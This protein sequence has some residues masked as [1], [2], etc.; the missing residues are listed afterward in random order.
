MSR[1]WF[2]DREFAFR[3]MAVLADAGVSPAV[4]GP[5]PFLHTVRMGLE[6]IYDMINGVVW[7]QAH[8]DAAKLAIRNT[9]TFFVFASRVPKE[10]ELITAV[11][12]R[13]VASAKQLVTIDG[14]GNTTF[15]ELV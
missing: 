7:Y 6:P 10:E 11:L 15:T 13:K 1:T 12:E 8:R 2:K 3:A 9:E 5:A 14:D 4:V